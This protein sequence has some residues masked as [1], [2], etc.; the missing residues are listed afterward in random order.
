MGCTPREDELSQAIGGNECSLPQLFELSGTSGH[1]PMARNASSH[2]ASVSSPQSLWDQNCGAPPGRPEMRRVPHRPSVG[3]EA[4]SQVPHEDPRLGV[5]PLPKG[6]LQGSSQGGRM[7][8]M[9]ETFRRDRRMSGRERS[10]LPI[11][12]GIRRCFLPE[13]G[14]GSR[15]PFLPQLLR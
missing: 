4:L 10:R 7:T 5:Q 15:L 1:D 13:R 6:P 8:R 14:G 3:G 11:E 12:R 9:D 2:P